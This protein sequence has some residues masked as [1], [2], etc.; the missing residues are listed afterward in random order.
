MIS[1]EANKRNPREVV[2]MATGTQGEPSAVLASWQWDSI[3]S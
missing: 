2:I 1:V 3:T